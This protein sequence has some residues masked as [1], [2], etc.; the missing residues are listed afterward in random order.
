MNK[1]GTFAISTEMWMLIAKSF[2]TIFVALAVFSLISYGVTKKI[3]VGDLENEIITRSLLQGSNC[4]IYKD[5]ARTY[6]GI[7]DLSKFKGEIDNCLS[8]SK[9]GVKLGLKIQDQN[10]ESFIR[11]D[12]YELEKRFCPFKQYKC[13]SRVV[14]VLVKENDKLNKGKLTISVVL[15]NG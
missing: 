4:F 7:V 12:F 15:K 1:K 9:T 2:V 13:S 8:S 10:Y 6:P 11:K 3:N 5:E 14:E